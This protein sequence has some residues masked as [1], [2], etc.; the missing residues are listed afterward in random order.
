MSPFRNPSDLSRRTRVGVVCSRHGEALD[1][2]L[3][4]ILETAR[5]T[6]L[7]LLIG[8]EDA[9]PTCGL[10]QVRAFS[11][12]AP[13]GDRIRETLL[14][15]E[16]GYL[17]YLDRGWLELHGL[18]AS[19]TRGPE[20]QSLFGAILEELRSAHEL[21]LL[22]SIARFSS[23]WA[24][25]PSLSDSVDLVREAD[26]GE[27]TRLRRRAE[28]RP[29]RVLVRL[30]SDA[31]SNP[32]GDTVAMEKTAFAL[33]GLGVELDID[34]DLTREDEDYDLVHLY[35]FCTPK[36]VE[37]QARRAH[38]RGVPF[39][40]TTLYEDW[41]RFFLPMQ[42]YNALYTGYVRSNQPSHLWSIFIEK[43]EKS[44][45]ERTPQPC[46]NNE[47]AGRHAAALLASGEAE[48]QTIY[49][50]L[51]D[52]V[53]VFITPFGVDREDDGDDGSLF[54]E[55]TGITEPFIYCVGR[56]ELRKNQLALMKAL[57]DVPET[58]VLAGGGFSY[59]EECVD[60]V[61]CFQR[62]GRTVVLPRLERA[63]LLSGY[64][65]ARVHALP[66]WYELPGLVSLEA[67]SRGCAVVASSTG[68][69][70]DYLGDD[71]F[72]CTPE[73]VES[74]RL[75]VLKAW[76]APKNQRLAERGRS[77]TWE[78]CARAVLD[79]YCRVLGRA[80]DSLPEPD[81]ATRARAASVPSLLELPPR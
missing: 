58:L 71:A 30:R 57:E 39:V 15:Q 72:Y 36:P 34:L 33:R 10:P 77:F 81:A 37:E 22:A 80:P 13:S 54:R 31:Y 1:T 24:S 18:E 7:V 32:G 4:E 61:K 14:S 2:E 50:N 51:G 78:R 23:R 76:F 60:L 45:A 52:D 70:Y 29:L 11:R 42:A 6:G 47:W 17:A 69:I 67:A 59:Q 63:V 74:I 65:A 55:A 20:G 75:A 21:S 9:E 53:P 68:T 48:R 12:T 8:D 79:V 25:A 5:G 35:N 44:L 38:A 64:R 41:P 28:T 16:I 40:V 62:K 73:D 66:S 43:G 3:L 46:A 19:V 49:R 26:R 56:I 27:G